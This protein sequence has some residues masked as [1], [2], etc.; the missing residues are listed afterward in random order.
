M[1]TKKDCQIDSVDKDHSAEI[2]DFEHTE[3]EDDDTQDEGDDP[4]TLGG[5]TSLLLLLSQDGN[6]SLVQ[7]ND[8]QSQTD[9]EKERKETREET[10]ETGGVTAKKHAV[11]AVKDSAVGG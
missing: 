10:K 1:Q 9:I 3:E 6:G 11:K 2:T 7:D 8:G 4:N 5:N